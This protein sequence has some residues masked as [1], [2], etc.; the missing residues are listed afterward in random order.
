MKNAH[1]VVLLV[2]VLGL[3]GG[4]LVYPRPPELALM[5]Y[6]NQQY[7][8]ARAE[9]ENLLE[10][11]DASANV[12][13]P[14]SD[15]YLIY[16]EMDKAV[17][18]MEN[19]VQYN[20]DNIEARE[21]LSKYYQQTQRPHDYLGSLEK[22]AEVQPSEQALRSLSQLYNA[23]GRYRQQI[24]VLKRI[25]QDY[26]AKPH[27][28]LDLAYL[29]AAEGEMV[30]ASE[31]LRRLA[32]EHPA[33]FDIR[34]REFL[35]SLSLDLG[36][37]EEAIT[38]LQGYAGRGGRWTAYYER[39]LEGA[40][41]YNELFAFW[42]RQ[43]TRPDV[44]DEEKREISYRYENTLHKL[45]REEKRLTFLRQQLRR[46]DLDESMRRELR[47]RY[48]TALRQNHRREALLAFLLE[49]I[50]Q[51]GL[52]PREREAFTYRYETELRKAKRQDELF[53]FWRRQLARS[54]L[55]ASER[56]EMSYR[57]QTALSA[58]GRR[59][60]LLALLRQELSRP[61][62]GKKD[63][64][65]LAYRALELGDKLLAE[66][67]YLDLAADAPPDSPYVSQLLYIWGPRPEPFGMQWI[68]ERA[69]SAQGEQRLGWLHRLLDVGATERVLKLGQHDLASLGYSGEPVEFQM[70]VLQREEDYPRLREV[71]TQAIENSHDAAQL[72]RYIRRADQVGFT[73]LAM[74][75]SWRLMTL[76][77]D[78]P[79][80]LRRLG[81]QA[82]AEQRWEDAFELLGRY[83]RLDGSGS[84]FE[85][86]YFYAELLT[87]RGSMDMALPYY[88]RVVQLLDAQPE[89]G[90]R[91]ASV[92]AQ[93]LYRLGESD[94]AI[95]AFQDL[96]TA[97][98]DNDD[99]R[100]DFATVLIETG[101]IE[102]AG[103]I[104]AARGQ[105]I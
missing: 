29:L 86:N 70:D 10:K 30:E 37:Y 76:S 26:D 63:K 99:L 62:L 89:L 20:P 85:S 75:A 68:E 57:Y 4:Y 38:Y 32:R 82:Y 9:Y 50:E 8:A 94:N 64:E 3:I 66:R 18:L 103:E 80:M 54:D 73:D 27:D 98:P 67:A 46:A 59:K 78:D 91:K 93:S 21:R 28:Y 39:A 45:G 53:A 65:A 22:R 61:D 51:P 90:I 13:L 6:R 69:R 19:F 31:I 102:R 7:T 17:K 34:A 11:G 52:S 105:G 23:E 101:H 72:R 25:V 43:L 104:L 1:F 96:L 92:R 81:L 48:E 49:Q 44:S 33:F 2:I 24:E 16:G 5:H 95:M 47:E 60:E 15:L 83:L 42:D 14:L 40:T 84:D 71:L 35:V 12:V 79:G 58:A 36:Q 97:Y 41:R 56:R 100:A 74:D 87:R 88:R 55:G 77:P